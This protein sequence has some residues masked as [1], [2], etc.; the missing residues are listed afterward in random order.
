VRA[1][2][3][4]SMFGGI[5]LAAAAGLSFVHPWGDVR[6]VGKEGEV[7]GGSDVPQQVRQV[8]ETKCADCHSNRTHW[9][10]YSRLAPGSWLMEHDVSEGRAALN[11]SRWENLRPEE[12]IDALSKIVAEVRS[13]EMPPMAYTMMHP[14][15]HVSDL[16]MQ[17]I[18]AWARGE[19]RRLRSAVEAKKEMSGQ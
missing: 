17:T 9:P 4:A 1:V 12:R 11:F 10:M 2:R 18:A 3:I 13:E 5:L 8:L 6:N 14:R 16:E 7:L 15:R 19:R